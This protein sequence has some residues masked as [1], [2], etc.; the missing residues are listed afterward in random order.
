MAFNNKENGSIN[1]ISSI[2]YLTLNFSS[3]G[4]DSSKAITADLLLAANKCICMAVSSNSAISCAVNVVESNPI[5][6]I[7]VR[8]RNINDKDGSGASVCNVLCLCF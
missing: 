2:Q 5:T 8:C 3:I 7:T 6:Q 1:T 4:G